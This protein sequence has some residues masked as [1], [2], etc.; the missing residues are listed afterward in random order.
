MKMKL[1]IDPLELCVIFFAEDEKALEDL[2][3]ISTISDFTPQ[4]ATTDKDECVATIDEFQVGRV[5]SK[6]YRVYWR[7]KKKITKHYQT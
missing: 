7:D 1:V 2:N 6:D 4:T 3:Q 5:D